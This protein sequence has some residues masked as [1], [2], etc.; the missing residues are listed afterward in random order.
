MELKVILLQHL[1][2]PQERKADVI[3]VSQMEH[4]YQLLSSTPYPS[5]DLSQDTVSGDDSG[6]LESSSKKK[7]KK[8]KKRKDYASDETL[9]VSSFD[10]SLNN[11][12]K[13]KKKD[14]DRDKQNYS[15]DISKEVLNVS[16]VE[17]GHNVS[18][19]A[20]S[21]DTK[22]ERKERRRSEKSQANLNSSSGL[23]VS[24]EMSDSGSSNAT[25]DAMMTPITAKS[26]ERKK[27]KKEKKVTEVFIYI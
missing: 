13:K 25:I 2:C 27:K 18:A 21:K 12:R 20:F 14:K 23:S 15:A 7:K 19:Q 17:N 11:S 5:H 9:N 4:L 1:P 16:L 22:K 8:S 6:S 24:L 10:L 3:P 26:S